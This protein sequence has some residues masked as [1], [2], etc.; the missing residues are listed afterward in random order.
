MLFPN[1]IN[2]QRCTNAEPTSNPL[3]RHTNYLHTSSEGLRTFI[4]IIVL[5]QMFVFNAFQRRLKLASWDYSLIIAAHQ[6]LPTSS[7]Q[8]TNCST[9]R[10]KNIGLTG[11]SLRNSL[12]VYTIAN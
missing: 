1:A 6:S 7:N 5:E 4:G 9:N 11:L 10:N 8:I 2:A 3:V 12:V